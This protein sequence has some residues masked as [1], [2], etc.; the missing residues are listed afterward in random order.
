MTFNDYPQSATNNA[1]RALKFREETQNV[2]KCGTPVGWARANQLAKREPISLETVKRMAAFNRHR[3]NKDVP[4][5][6]GCGGLMWDAWGGTEGVDWAINKLKELE[7]MEARKYDILNDITDTGAEVERLAAFLDAAGGEPISVNIASDGGEVFLGLKLAGLISNYKGETVSNIYGL[8]ASISTIIALAAD[9]TYID[10]YGFFMIHNAWST[11]QGNKEEIKKQQRTLKEIDSILTAVYVDKI[12][13]SGK[14]INGSKEETRAKIEAL[15]NKE[16]FLSAERAFNLGLV[17][18]YIKEPSE[19]LEK[20]GFSNVQNKAQFLNNFNNSKMEKSKLGLFS[21]LL[22]VFGFNKT[23]VLEAADGLETPVLDTPEAKEEATTEEPQNKASKAMEEEVEK[24]EKEKEEIK[25]L[26]D[27]VKAME[28]EKKAL[29]D[30]LK[31]MQEEMQKEKK[32][33]AEL[34]ANIEETASYAKESK[35]QEINSRLFTPERAKALNE[36]FKKAL[37]K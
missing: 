2:N 11:L 27:R 28:E 12:E 10:K 17:D 34:R 8:A 35:G 9:K 1:L 31:A 37:N 32:E 18:G 3:Q 13:R 29:E 6:E 33:K 21:A 7:K 25:E 20:I 36:M 23:E 5:G 26:E 15:M 30:R 16:S 22:S 24:E 14:L 4:Y 19:A